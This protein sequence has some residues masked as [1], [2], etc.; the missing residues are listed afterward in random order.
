MKQQLNWTLIAASCPELKL[1]RWDSVFYLIAFVGVILTSIQKRQFLRKRKEGSS[2]LGTLAYCDFLICLFFLVIYLGA[3]LSFYYQ[4]DTLAGLRIASQLTIKNFQILYDVVM[5]FV[6]LYLI[7]ERFLWTCSARTRLR[8]KMFTASKQKFWLLFGTTIYSIFPWFIKPIVKSNIPFCDI[9]PYP[10][11]F[12]DPEFQVIQMYIVPGIS[13]IASVATFAFAIFTIPLLSKVEEGEEPV[14]PEELN[15]ESLK[16]K[17][18]NG[19]TTNLIRR[20]I[21]CM[22]VVYVTFLVRTVCYH[23]FINPLTSDL[24]EKP[25]SARNLTVWWYDTISVV[26][27]ASRFIVYYFFCRNQMVTEFPSNAPGQ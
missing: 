16:G 15:L 8:W 5:N 19:L 10:I 9:E 22:L 20:S 17:H 2:F 21:I 7:V 11:L 25:R 6:V 14:I 27:S 12:A 3:S 4:N 13:A 1:S 23:I 24:F 18:P 26:F